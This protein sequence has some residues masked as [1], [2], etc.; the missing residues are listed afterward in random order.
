MPFTH[1]LAQRALTGTERFLISPLFI[2]LALVVIA[3]GVNAIRTRRLKA[4]AI[5]RLLY[6]KRE[7]T[8][9]I[10]VVTGVCICICGAAIIVG[11]VVM[12][13]LG[14]TLLPP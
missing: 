10:A 6:G 2:L 4:R 12:M 5:E 1:L 11:V 14:R 8:G 13:V 9:P 7:W 3:A